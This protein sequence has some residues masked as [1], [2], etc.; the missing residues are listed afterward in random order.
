MN[1]DNYGLNGWHLDHIEPLSNAKTEEDVMRLNHYTN[2][3]PLWGEDNIKK[4]NHS[5]GNVQLRC[6]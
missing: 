1:W 2:L 3:R 5:P 4:S 6:I